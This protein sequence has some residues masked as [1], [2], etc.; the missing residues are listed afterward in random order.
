MI[1]SQ[2][3]LIPNAL[4]GLSFGPVTNA[5]DIVVSGYGRPVFTPGATTTTGSTTGGEP[6]TDTKDSTE[7]ER[8]IASMALV[9]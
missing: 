9:A 1:A 8:D 4:E 6:P 3:D 7:D 2:A 5:G